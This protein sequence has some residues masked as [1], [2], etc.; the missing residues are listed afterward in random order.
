MPPN[1]QP[2]SPDS[3]DVELR[4]L[5]KFLKGAG[6]APLIKGKAETRCVSADHAGRSVKLFQKGKGVLVELFEGKVLF[7]PPSKPDERVLRGEPKH[8][9]ASDYRHQTSDGAGAHA[10]SWLLRLE[11]FA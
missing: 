8:R 5:A 9:V 1:P 3:N 7:V 2:V 10:V 6:F 4:A 11:R